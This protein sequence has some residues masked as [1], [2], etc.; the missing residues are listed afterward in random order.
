MS[1]ENGPYRYISAPFR[2]GAN[3]KKTGG[4]KCNHRTYGQI[5][6]IFGVY[7]NFIWKWLLLYFNRPQTVELDT[8][9]YL[10]FLTIFDLLKSNVPVIPH[11]DGV[12]FITKRQRGEMVARLFWIA[13]NGREIFYLL[14]C[15]YPCRV[16][17]AWNLGEVKGVRHTRP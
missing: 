2:G 12:N 8:L 15:S 3:P 7:V 14:L 13:S 16:A 6:L 17:L 1:S 9:T 11:P 10:D 5:A 4:F